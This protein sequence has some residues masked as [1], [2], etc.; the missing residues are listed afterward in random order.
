[1]HAFNEKNNFL[2]KIVIIVNLIVVVFSGHEGSLTA[3]DKALR[4]Y[5][6]Q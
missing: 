6:S 2:I 5:S 4:L 1:M 3:L